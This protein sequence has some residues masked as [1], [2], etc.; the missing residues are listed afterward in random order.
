MLNVFD[1]EVLVKR[2]DI[3]IALRFGFLSE[4]S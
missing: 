4:A 2:N 3:E 1:G